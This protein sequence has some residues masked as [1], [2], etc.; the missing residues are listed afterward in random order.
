[1]VSDMSQILYNLQFV[2]HCRGEPGLAQGIASVL[3]IALHCFP[4]HPVLFCGCDETPAASVSWSSE[5]KGTWAGRILNQEPH[6]FLQ[7]AV[8]MTERCFW[9]FFCLKSINSGV[10]PCSCSLCDSFRRSSSV[11]FQEI[12][13][14]WML[15]VC[16]RICFCA[17]ASTNPWKALSRG[18]LRSINMQRHSHL[19]TVTI[20]VG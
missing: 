15:C 5:T 7:G 12:E 18:R 3:E 13:A 17:G 6:G 2:V 11:V 20:Y 19:T 16:V 1:M 8:E 4:S 14:G 9:W 10:Q